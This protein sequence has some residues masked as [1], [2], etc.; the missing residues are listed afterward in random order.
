MDERT[1]MELKQAVETHPEDLRS[2]LALTQRLIEEGELGEA[3]G[4]I[5]R[6]KEGEAGLTRPIEEAEAKWLLGKIRLKQGRKGE[7]RRIAGTLLRGDAF[8]K[9]KGLD[10]MVEVKQGGHPLL[11]A[12]WKYIRHTEGYERAGVFDW[13]VALFWPLLAGLILVLGFIGDPG[14]HPIWSLVPLFLGLWIDQIA[15]ALVRWEI[16]VAYDHGAI[17]GH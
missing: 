4:M 13:F 7:T 8:A 3:E 15:Q 14:P 5:L 2:R 10:L 9:S 1:I 6:V 12:C 17:P 16:R 11:S